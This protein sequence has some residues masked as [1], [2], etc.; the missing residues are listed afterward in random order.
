MLTTQLQIEFR[1]NSLAWKNSIASILVELQKL[2][3]QAQ[4][5]EIEKALASWNLIKQLWS[6]LP[7]E[8]LAKQFK[9]LQMQTVQGKVW[10]PKQVDNEVVILHLGWDVLCF[11]CSL[12]SAW[13]TWINYCRL[14]SSETYNACIYPTNL[15]WYIVRAGTNLYPMI[16]EEGQY[17][18]KR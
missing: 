18:I 2:D 9:D 11:Q 7:E 10:L 14:H 5:I 4:L 15:R 16:F 8:P 13:E 6:Y 12:N 1:K 17:K 3:S